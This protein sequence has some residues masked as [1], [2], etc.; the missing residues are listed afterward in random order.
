MRDYR[1]ARNALPGEDLRSSWHGLRQADFSQLH[2]VQRA[3]GWER[4]I[5]LRITAHDDIGRH[6]PRARKIK[7]IPL[8]HGISSCIQKSVCYFR[9]I[10]F[11]SGQSCNR[12][13]CVWAELVNPIDSDVRVNVLARGTAPKICLDPRPFRSTRREK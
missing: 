5:T 11:F 9:A 6:K 3:C 12:P 7:K 1:E 13:I 10:G 8:K 4:K 2:F